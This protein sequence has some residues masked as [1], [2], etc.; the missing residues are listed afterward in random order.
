MFVQKMIKELYRK[1]IPTLFIKLDISKAFDTVNWSYL[2]DIMTYL[3]FGAR[4]RDWIA[5]LG[6]T[7]SSSFLINGEPGRKIIHRRGQ[8]W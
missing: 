6:G 7:T 8:A 2:L 1:K 5:A 3:G 4:W